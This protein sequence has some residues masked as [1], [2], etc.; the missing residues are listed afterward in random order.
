MRKLRI[1]ILY[2]DNAGLALLTSMLKSLGHGIE[3]ATNDR[4]AVRLMERNDIDLVL[5]GVDPADADALELLT[6]VRRKHRDVPVVLLFPRLHPERAKEA[7][8]LGAM[9]VLKYPVPAAELRAAVLQALEQSESRPAQPGVGALA[10]QSSAAPGKHQP[11]L[12]AAP[13]ALIAALADHSTAPH[14]GNSASKVAAGALPA[15]PATLLAAPALNNV[16]PSAASGPAGLSHAPALRIDVLARELGLMGHDPGW[17]QIL[18]LA[19]VVGSTRASVLIVGEPGTGKSLLARL[20]HALGAGAERPLVILESTVLGEP[21]ATPESG[22]TQP[23]GAS[24]AVP[25]WSLKLSQARGGTLYIDEV[26]ALPIE[27]QHHLLRELQYRDYEASTGHPA[28]PNEVRFV[29]STGENLVALV[30]QGRFRQELYHRAGVI[31]LMLPPL[32]H[33][34]TDVELLAET[35]RARY[36]QEF[37]KAVAGFSRD[38]LDALQRHDWPGNVREL[39]AAVQRAVALCNGPRITS[40]HLAPILNHHRQARHAGSPPRP[41]LPMG[42]RP[43]KEALEEPEKRIIIQALQAFNWNRQETARVLDINRTTLYKKMKKYGLL[44]DEPS[45]AN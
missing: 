22:A 19:A 10:P 42:V 28:Q 31:S 34:G 16:I 15:S 6:Y 7:L 32:R 18:E 12:A 36:S 1:L 11:S 44:I 21:E 35:F 20:I 41:H 33:R 39:E 4:V 13:S 26:A 5:A 24:D 3:E 8:R 30:E 37:H 23:A 9:A 25:V 40:S 45:W 17:R 14:A 2:P 27:L 43:L 38:A 29:M